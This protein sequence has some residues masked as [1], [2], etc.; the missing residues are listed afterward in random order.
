[1]DQSKGKKISLDNLSEANFRLVISAAASLIGFFLPWI[2]MRGF[3]SST[4]LG[5]SL[6]SPFISRASGFPLG[7]VLLT[8]ISALVVLY[9]YLPKLLGK[10]QK[11]EK[12][13]RNQMI[14]QIVMI[15]I[16]FI[17]FILIPFEI[18]TWSGGVVKTSYG[19]WLAI[20]AQIG[21]LFYAFQGSTET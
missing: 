5:V 17:P 1:M 21:M 15:V 10:R 6:I 3:L 14:L 16:G 9:L 20:L 19:L 4:N 18:K 11:D 12:L 8:P 2:V 13:T 7:L